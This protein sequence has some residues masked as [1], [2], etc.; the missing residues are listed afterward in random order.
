MIVICIFKIRI[1]SL[2]VIHFCHNF[3]FN[4]IENLADFCLSFLKPENQYC[5]ICVILM[6]PII[7]RI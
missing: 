4:A 6:R 3:V 7:D 2:L 1:N 5:G